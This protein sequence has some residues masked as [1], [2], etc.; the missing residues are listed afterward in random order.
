[1]AGVL[2]P[3]PGLRQLAQHVS[4]ELLILHGRRPSCSAILC[5]NLGQKLAPHAL[6]PD[7]LRGHHAHPRC[8][9]TGF[10]HLSPLRGRH[11]GLSASEGRGAK[12]GSVAER[13]HPH[14]RPPSHCPHPPPPAQRSSEPSGV[15][16]PQ[17]ASQAAEGRPGLS[18][19]DELWADHAQKQL[20]ET[21]PGHNWQK[22]PELHTFGGVT[23]VLSQS[24][25]AGHAVSTQWWGTSFAGFLSPPSR[26]QRQR[27]ATKGQEV[28]PAETWH[29]GTL[30]QEETS[31]GLEETKCPAVSLWGDTDL[32]PAASGR[33]VLPTVRGSLEA[34]GSPK[35]I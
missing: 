9:D 35:E 6:P 4:S 1:M 22:C 17:L 33:G 32:R 29:C 12:V 26:C 8:P 23:T 3:Q 28:R 14:P 20:K 10:C 19:R 21:Y 25:I 15:Q 11:R 2:I 13:T 30:S 24:E 27:N 31:A 16:S 34:G 7:K 5:W 18:P